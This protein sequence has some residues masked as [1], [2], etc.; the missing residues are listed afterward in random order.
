[1]KI[2][3]LCFEAP[4]HSSTVSYEE[5]IEAVKINGARFV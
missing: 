2:C 3:E 4:T 1:M 5:A